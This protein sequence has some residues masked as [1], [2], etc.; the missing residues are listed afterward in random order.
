MRIPRMT[1][2]PG[3]WH[4]PV[5]ETVT[6]RA[7]TFDMLR[8]EI[9]DW[10]VSN[11]QE[12][13][14]IEAEID[15]YFCKKWP[16]R[17]YAEDKDGHYPPGVTA[18]DKMSDRVLRWVASMVDIRRVPQGGWPLASLKTAESRAKGCANCPRNIAWPSGCGGCDQSVKTASA[19]VR[20]HRAVPVENLQACSL[21]G[22]DN[23]SAVHL[24][25]GSLGVTD[26]DPRRKLTP[27]HCGWHVTSP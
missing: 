12:P 21:F 5:S 10:R 17:C 4:F 16:A 9:F 13:G 19:R 24:T 8:Q 11:A 1:G 3:Q 15:A 20:S 7:L 26:D 22:W 14:N 18:E 6:L 23:E 27:I 2:P 25:D